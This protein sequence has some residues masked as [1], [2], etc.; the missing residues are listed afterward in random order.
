M[1]TDLNISNNAFNTLPP[2]FA[3]QTSLTRLNISQNAMSAIPPCIV[4]LLKLTTLDMSA[5]YLQHLAV[6]PLQ[7]MKPKDLWKRILSEEDGRFVYIHMLTKEKVDHVSNYTGIGTAEATDLH[8][9]QPA[10]S[11]A[12]NRRYRGRRNTTDISIVIII[13]IVTPGICPTGYNPLIPD[14]LFSD[15]AR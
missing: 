7:L 13:S 2:E 8:V 6:L 1:L 11:I 5:N 15:I 4:K 12:Y 10:G 3:Q 14:P 9:F